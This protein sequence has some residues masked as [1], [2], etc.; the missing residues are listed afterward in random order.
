MWIKCGKCGL[1][2]LLPLS[3]Y[4][5]NG[6]FVIFKAWTCTNPKCGHTLRIDKGEVSEGKK[7][8]EK[9]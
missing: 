4:G 9:D 7:K 8:I 3:D 2:D 5:Q 1:G 6:S